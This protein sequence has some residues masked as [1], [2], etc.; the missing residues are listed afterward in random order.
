MSAEAIY[1]AKNLVDNPDFIVLTRYLSEQAANALL[2]GSIEDADTN[3]RNYQ[4][5]DVLIT[6]ATNLSLQAIVDENG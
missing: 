5:V 4:A 1:A 3:L 6:M 2:G